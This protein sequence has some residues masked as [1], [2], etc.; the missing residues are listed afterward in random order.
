[1]SAWTEGFQRLSTDQKTRVEEWVVLMGFVA[2]TLRIPWKTWVDGYL[3]DAISKPVDYAFLDATRVDGFG[4][5][6]ES[7]TF[8]R[9]AD[10]A[11]LTVP[12]I[13]V[14]SRNNLGRLSPDLQDQI[15]GM[16][17]HGEPSSLRLQPSDVSLLQKIF[18]SAKAV[19]KLK[20]PDFKKVVL[21]RSFGEHDITF[22]I[23]GGQELARI[24]VVEFTAVMSRG[25]S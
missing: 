24:N 7:V 2:N 11:T 19:A 20:H 8:T 23:D 9:R 3:Q 17:Q 12:R 5:G 10:L 4:F 18:P 1:M 15:A 6:P 13:P 22:S 16:L 25:V 14:R 21:S